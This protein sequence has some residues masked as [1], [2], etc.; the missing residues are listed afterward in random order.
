MKDERK[1]KKQLVSELEELRPQVTELAR[2]RDLLD[3]LLDNVPDHVYFK[4]RESR[5]LR[6]SRA[7]FLYNCILLTWLPVALI[8][9]PSPTRVRDTSWLLVIH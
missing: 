2:E 5:F 1:T 9:L 7:H 3:A 4:D 6:N 8:H